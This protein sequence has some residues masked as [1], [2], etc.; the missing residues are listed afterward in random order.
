M[1]GVRDKPECGLGRLCTS[2][3]C[4]DHHLIPVSVHSP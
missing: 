1:N 4:E 2:N 3:V